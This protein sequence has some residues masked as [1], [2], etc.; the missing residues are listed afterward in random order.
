MAATCVLDERNGTSPGTRH[1]N[2]SNCNFGSDD[3]YEL[4]VATYPITVGENSYEKWWIMEFT[5]TFN[6]VDNLKVWK[7]SG[8][9]VTGE[10]ILTNCRETSYG[11]AE[12]YTTPTQSTSSVA[13]QTLPT[14]EPSGANLGIGG[15]LSGSLSSPGDSDYCVMQLQTTGSTPVGDGNQKVLRFQWDES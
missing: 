7:V 9:Y 10:S 14:T 4:V 13:T 3:D 8:N 1:D 6:S 2:V 11:G 15:S 12:T 5:G